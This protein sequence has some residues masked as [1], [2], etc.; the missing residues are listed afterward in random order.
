M[1][2]NNIYNKRFKD[3]SWETIKRYSKAKKEGFCIE[4]LIL[5]INS[6]KMI[7]TTVLESEMKKQ[8]KDE[9]TITKALRENKDLNDLIK[10]AGPNKFNILNEKQ[11]K[12]I[13]KYY[14][15][16]CDTVHGFINNKVNY[17]EV[18][19]KINDFSKIYKDIQ[20]NFLKMK[21]IPKQII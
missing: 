14:K 10:L 1:K 9:R 2:D 20:D 21:I 12:I 19:Q 4:A 15:F 7:L 18:C 11:I 8:K 6:L 13:E 17:K 16:R 5:S 3:K